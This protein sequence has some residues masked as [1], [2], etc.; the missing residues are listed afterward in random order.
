[1]VSFTA[2]GDASCSDAGDAD[3]CETESTAMADWPVPRMLS[4]MSSCEVMPSIMPS[5]TNCWQ[6]IEYTCESMITFG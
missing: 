5:S 1:M 3:G 6:S 2:S 4:S